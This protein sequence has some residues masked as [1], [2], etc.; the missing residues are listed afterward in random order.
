MFLFACGPDFDGSSPE[1]LDETTQTLGIKI[2]GRIDAMSQPLAGAFVIALDSQGRQTGRTKTA[3]NGNYVLSAPSLPH[4]IV[5]KAFNQVPRYETKPALTS[6][7]S[8]RYRFNYDVGPSLAGDW[9]TENL[10][11]MVLAKVNGEKIVPQIAW[12]NGGGVGSPQDELA[13]LTV[14]ARLPKFMSLLPAGTKPAPN[15]EASVER[16]KTAQGDYLEARFS[17]ELNTYNLGSG[18]TSLLIDQIV[19]TTSINYSNERLPVRIRV[20]CPNCS[21]G[22]Q[23][24]RDGHVGPNGPGNSYRLNVAAPNTAFKDIGTHQLANHI[25]MAKALGITSGY[26]DGT[27]KPNNVLTR[28][29]LVSLLVRALG[30]PLANP[31]TPSF[32]DVKKTDWFYQVVETGRARGLLSGYTDG[33]FRPNNSVTRAEL[34]AFLVNAARWPLSTFETPVFTDV[35]SSYWAHQKIE[36]AF[37]FCHAVEPRSYWTMKFE[38]TKPATRAEAVA[39]IVRMMNCFTGDEVK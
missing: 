38:P 25:A 18:Y 15:W 29:E 36:T 6:I 10:T 35:A 3:A 7:G 26:A 39:G 24:L 2:E 28:V 12:G 16:K 22:F 27:F 33:T 11:F 1:L 4:K 34:A 23:D 37:G 32:S 21:G 20:A 5:V 13:D 31:A 19:A 14:G 8:G 30:V 17:S 9:T